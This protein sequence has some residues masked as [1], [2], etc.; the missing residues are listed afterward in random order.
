MKNHLLFILLFTCLYGVTPGQVYNYNNPHTGYMVCVWDEAPV[1]AGPDKRSDILS[2]MQFG[3][4]AE[5]LGDEAFVSFENN[6]YYKVRSADGR[7]GWV[8]E[9]LFVPEGGTAVLL[10]EGRIFKRPN[11]VSTITVDRFYPGEIVILEDVAGQWVRLVSRNRA[12]TGWIEGLE[13]VSVE[14]DDIE[15]ATLMHRID[16]EPSSAMRKTLLEE[17]A[18]VAQNNQ[19]P[20]YD[21]ILARYQGELSNRTLADLSAPVSSPTSDRARSVTSSESNERGVYR[22]EEPEIVYDPVTGKKSRKV[23]ETGKIYEVLGPKNPSS[24]FFAYH[25]TLP[26]GSKIMIRI[27]DNQGYIELEIINRLRKDNPALLGL[28]NACIEALYGSA[29]PG[30]AEIFYYE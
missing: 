15:L 9:F 25:K 3:E 11:T 30:S 8:N 24:I 16:E 5:R 22:G 2:V 20:M 23:T 6:T 4:E 13:K 27:P 7:V 21:L 18:E 17:L 28:S 12:R 1:F 19:T 26:I 14:P 10:Q 29:K